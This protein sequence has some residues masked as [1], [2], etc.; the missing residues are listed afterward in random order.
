M[1][2]KF[3]T[4]LGMK[5]CLKNF[6]KWMK[7]LNAM[8]WLI[9]QLFIES[10]GNGTGDSYYESLTFEIIQPKG[11]VRRF[12][13]WWLMTFVFKLSRWVRTRKNGLSFKWMLCSD[14]LGAPAPFLPPTFIRIIISHLSGGRLDKI[15]NHLLINFSSWMTSMESLR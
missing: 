13:K 2:T 11:M 14:S 1:T 8:N 10:N 9:S 7:S 3:P 4:R 6:I 12:T 5:M 15:C